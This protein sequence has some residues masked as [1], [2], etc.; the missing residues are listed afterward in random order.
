MIL[1]LVLNVIFRGGDFLL[2]VIRGYAGLIKIKLKSS[3]LDFVIRTGLVF[4]RMVILF[5][6]AFRKELGPP[7][8]PFVT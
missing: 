3:R 6:P 8:V 1:L 5:L 7:P 4:H 2:Q